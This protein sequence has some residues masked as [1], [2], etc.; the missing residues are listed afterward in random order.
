[1]TGLLPFADESDFCGTIVLSGILYGIGTTVARGE[2]QVI[3]WSWRIAGAVFLVDGVMCLGEVNRI[4]AAECLAA[5]VHG[6]IAGS[7][8]LGVTLSAL[9]AA[10]A[11]YR[12]FGLMTRKM[13]EQSRSKKRQREQ[14]ENERQSA[15]KRRRLDEEWERSRPER[16]RRQLEDAERQALDAR[17]K[18]QAQKRREDARIQCESFYSLHAPLIRR[19]FTKDMFDSFISR[20]MGDNRPPAE[21]E[22]RA[23]Q[24]QALIEQ[25]VQAVAP[26]KKE[27][28]IDALATWFL[29][30]KRRIDTLSIDDEL[31]DEHLAHLNMRYSELSQEILEKMRP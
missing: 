20:Y 21:V 7:L 4:T 2:P 14:Q 18:Y 31:R 25:H 24:L 12:P 10:S 26:M 29:A 11:L 6:L 19:R 1:M 30:E 15:E 8:A 27:P 9:G 17:L 5:T 23:A 16:E 22:E 28:T 13:E 3:P